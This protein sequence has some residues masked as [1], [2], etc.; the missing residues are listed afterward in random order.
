M[1]FD[2]I[3][4]AASRLALGHFCII[5]KRSVVL[6]YLK[7]ASRLLIC[8]ILTVC[9]FC[10]AMENTKEYICRAVVTVVDHLGSA[11]ANLDCRISQTNAFSEAEFRI[12]CLKQVS[13]NVL[14]IL[15]ICHWKFIKL[16]A[17]T[18]CWTCLVAIG[19]CFDRDFSCVNNMLTS[20]L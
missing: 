15:I 17:S 19:A 1:A 14:F 3:A 6:W 18:N 2:K 8:G 4:K 13:S 9:I 7:T 5:W 11:S 16:L 12:N 10:S 20:L